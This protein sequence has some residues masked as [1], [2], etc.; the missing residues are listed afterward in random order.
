[1][2]GMGNELTLWHGI[3]VLVFCVQLLLGVGGWLIRKQI[4]DYGKGEA[5]QTAAITELTSALNDLRVELPKEYV[6]KGD[7]IHAQAMQTEEIKQIRVEAAATRQEI[8][9][10]RGDLLRLIAVLRPAQAQD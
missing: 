8:S 2:T 3:V 6:A 7:M 4:E 1:M 9:A 5:I 10:M